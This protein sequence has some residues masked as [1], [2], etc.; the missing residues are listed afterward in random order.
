MAGE[1]KPRSGDS[2]GGGHTPKGGLGLLT[3]GA[4]GVVYGDIGTSPLYAVRESFGEHHD[5][6]ATEANVLGLLSLITWSLIIVIT[7][8]YLIFVLRADN[9]GEGGI[10]ALTSLATPKGN[11]TSRRWALILVG[12]FGTALLYG[13]GIITPAISVLSAVEGLEVAQPGISDLV[14]PIAV[15]ILIGVFSFQSKGT[16]TV[17]RLFGPVMLVWFGVLSVLG[18]THI[19]D[20]PSVLEAVNPVYA[21]DFFVNGGWEAYLVLGSVFLVVTGG[22]ALYADMGHF[23]RKPIRLGWFVMV[24]PALL[25]TY[26]GQ[27]ALIIGD[28]AAVENPFFEMAP[29]WFVLPL[30]ALATMATVIASQ[31]LISGAYSLTMQAIQLD[32]TPRMK[33]NHT[34]EDQMGQIYLPTINW[35]LMVSCIALVIGFRSSTNLAAAYGVAVTMTMFIT[36]ILFYVVAR[37]RWGWRKRKA[38]SV[39]APFLMIDI[40]FL[41]ANLIKIPDGGWLPLVVGAVVFGLMTTWRTGRVLV[42][43]R[44]RQGELPLA[45]FIKSLGKQKVTRVPGTA[46]FMTSQAAGAPAVLLHHVK[47]NKVLHE[48]VILMSVRNEEI[49]Y[50]EDDER[51]EF[52]DLG[53]KFYQVRVRYGFMESPDAPEVLRKLQA[54]GIAV[55]PLETTYYLGRETL[56]ATPDR[57]PVSPPSDEEIPLPH[58]A[59]WRKKLFIVMSRNAQSAT[60]FFN[61]PPNRVVEMGAQ[62]Q[63]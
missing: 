38:L 51:I 11:P 39:T 52:K 47:H 58:L 46:V 1:H 53:Q 45:T 19:L 18:L 3:L 61:L 16:G 9:D 20:N 32:Y 5:I 6:A 31:A 37:D 43:K 27:G 15:L 36:T 10:L 62:I 29:D 8:K 59:M 34:S 54:Y 22:E 13:D 12:L 23:G 48:Q 21:V 14:I 4:L 30:T 57:K 40:A 42:G 7:I 44:L 41:G 49:P 17:G 50:V 25:I 28:P 2:H 60:T 55:K 63:F 56:I 33:I 26:F 24:L 35:A